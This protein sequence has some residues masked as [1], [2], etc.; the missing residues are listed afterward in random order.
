MQKLTPYLKLLTMGQEAIDS[1]LAPIRALSAKKKA[2]LETCKL[3]ERIA[4]LE[5]ELTELCS[6]KDIDYDKII[7]K[8]DDIALAER[9]K[10][11][12]EKIINEMFP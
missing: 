10:G 12:F 7:D 8:F 4:T 6:N 2:E 9:R 3:D 5:T 11:Q 1:A